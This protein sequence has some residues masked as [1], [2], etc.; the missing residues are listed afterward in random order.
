MMDAR[1]LLSTLGSFSNAVLAFSQKNHLVHLCSKN[2][3]GDDLVPSMF[4]T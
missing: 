2:L 1:L 4:P 3:L